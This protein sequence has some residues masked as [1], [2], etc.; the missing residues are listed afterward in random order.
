MKNFNGN[1][2]LLN[3]GVAKE[4]YE[5]HSKDMPIIDYHCH[6]DAKEIYENRRFNTIT[7]AW[8]EADH[9]KWRAMRICGVD[10]YY[11]TGN[12]GDFEKFQKWSECL[13]KMFGSPLYHWAH[14][15]LKKFFS[16]EKPLSP[17][18][19][20]EIYD[21]CNEK[22]K[23]MTVREMIKLSRVKAIGTTNDPSEELT[24]HS[25]L[26]NSGYPVL[27][28]P[29]FRPDKAINI[30]RDGY[31][32]YIKK[33]AKSASTEITTLSDL[34]CALMARMDY[35]GSLGCRAA[36]HGMDNCVPF[37]NGDAE[38]IFEKALRGEN[39]TESE[40]EA[41]K[42]DLHLFCAREYAKRGWVMEIHFGVMRNTNSKNFA[43]LG[44]DTGFDTIG[45][46]SDADKLRLMLDRLE[47]EGHL[48]KTIIFPIY[49]G[50]NCVINTLAGSFQQ[51][52]IKGKVQQGAAWWFND[53]KSGME[54]WLKSFCDLFVLD[55]FVGMLTDSRSFL[56]YTRHDYFRRILCNFIGELVEKGEYPYDIKQLGQMVEN[57][58]YYNAKEF[59]NID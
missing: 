14:L 39:I 34:K 43:L 44:P 17:D 42:T 40:A 57:I 25:L 26:K 27:V 33:L 52:G 21:E 30:D 35:F 23:T 7:E 29:A 13:P 10:E 54:S 9:Y 55:S 37:E 28:F 32:D 8:L 3:C 1:D 47:S 53:T 41:F 45:I 24:Y 56:S 20:R 50:K 31:V 6:I 2:F 38:E 22:L 16:I 49:P 36:D 48:P 19:C 18:T 51:S 58:S 4:L 12:A 11:I 46:Y 15:E 5:N 59:F